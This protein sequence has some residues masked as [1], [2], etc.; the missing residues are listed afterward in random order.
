MYW[1]CWNV[2]NYHFHVLT[3]TQIEFT[4]R[5]SW[6]SNFKGPYKPPGLV[7]ADK[8]LASCF[9]QLP[10]SKD[11]KI[12]TF[13]GVGGAK[14]LF[15]IISLRPDRFFLS[16]LS[17]KRFMWVKLF[18]PLSKKVLWRLYLKL[19]CTAISLLWFRGQWMRKPQRGF[20]SKQLNSQEISPQNCCC[21]SSDDVVSPWKIT[22]EVKAEPH[23]NTASLSVK[24][25]LVIITFIHLKTQCVRFKKPYC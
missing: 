18:I 13:F 11:E 22:E 19:C 15:H 14:W 16:H 6:K 24:F 25:Y 21:L 17:I 8:E 4:Q 7:R 1:N 10:G 23:F 9:V 12:K 20:A 5:S 2:N 3:K